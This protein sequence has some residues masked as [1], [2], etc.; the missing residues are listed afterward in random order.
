MSL[1]KDS[2]SFTIGFLVVM[3]VVVAV[4]L[5]LVSS[6][7]AGIINKNKE[8]DTKS[9]ILKSVLTFESEDEEAAFY[10]NGDTVLSVFDNSITEYVID[11]LGNAT[12]KD[13]AFAI[14][15]KK[16]EK[17]PEE[18]RSYPLLV[19]KG[20]GKELYVFPMIG[21]GLWDKIWGYMALKG[22][23]ETVQGAAFDHAGE[24]P[25]L[26]A[27]IT[28]DWYRKQFSDKELYNEEGEYA[29]KVLKGEGNELD[30]YSVDGMS[31]ATFTSVG[32]HEMVEK[33]VGYYEPYFEKAKN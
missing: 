25:G 33:C 21:N 1:D 24:T 11:H 2:N 7:L 29:F 12:Q 19:Y 15:L 14:E 32:V 30:P 23:F 5:S 13:S 9:Q 4:S 3:V 26:G 27:K 31:G 10:A 28:D 16:E 6:A 8:V 17:K 22:D 20:E 18:E